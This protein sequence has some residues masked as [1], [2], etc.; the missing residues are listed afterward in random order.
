MRP[1]HTATLFRDI[2]RSD[3]P[4]RRKTDDVHNYIGPEVGINAAGLALPKGAVA[5]VSLEA[6]HR[7]AA[8]APRRAHSLLSVSGPRTWA[9]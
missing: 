6:V 9:A 4:V 8:A 2:D 7:H 5:G 1:L 3:L